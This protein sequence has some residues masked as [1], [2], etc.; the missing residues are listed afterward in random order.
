MV[1]KLERGKETKMLFCQDTAGCFQD[2]VSTVL[3]SAPGGEF[4]MELPEGFEEM[5]EESREENYPYADRPEIILEDVSEDAQIT[6]QFLEKELKETEIW[7]AVS[8]VLELTENTFPEYK[9]S[10]EYLYEAGSTPIGWFLLT[11]E[12]MEKEHVKAVFSVENRMAL[13]TLTY[14]IEK[15]FKWRPLFKYIFSSIKTLEE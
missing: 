5:T 11:M 15:N 13:F 2:S 12:D 3:W 7:D 1:G 4:F 14:P 10:P 6:L 8:Q 9:A